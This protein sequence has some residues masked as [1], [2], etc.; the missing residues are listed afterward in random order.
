MDAHRTVWMNKTSGMDN[1][2]SPICDVT[3]NSH[4]SIISINGTIKI[5][6]QFC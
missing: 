4:K 6:V 3:L 1:A 2:V 5:M